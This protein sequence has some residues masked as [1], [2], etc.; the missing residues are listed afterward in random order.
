VLTV[1]LLELLFREGCMLYELMPTMP[2][3]NLG[4]LVEELVRIMNQQRT[5]SDAL[6]VV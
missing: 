4:S 6:C 5:F 1:F 2:E 3:P